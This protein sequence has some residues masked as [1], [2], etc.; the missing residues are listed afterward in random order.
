MDKYNFLESLDSFNFHTIRNF[1]YKRDRINADDTIGQ[2]L[3]DLKMTNLKPFSKYMD[4]LKD[5]AK[6]DY[7]LKYLLQEF[8]GILNL[9]Q[10]LVGKPSG[11]KPKPMGGSRR[12]QLQ[13]SGL[14]G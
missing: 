14:M 8:K 13:Y 10:V 6:E 3:D 7:Y 5:T 1:G 2:I 9:M 11:S 4:Y 12:F